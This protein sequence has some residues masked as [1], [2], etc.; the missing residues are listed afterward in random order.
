[1]KFYLLFLKNSVI[2]SYVASV[3]IDFDE[4]PSYVAVL[5]FKGGA[6]DG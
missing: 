3:A 4:N 2:I 1:L 6:A 5:D